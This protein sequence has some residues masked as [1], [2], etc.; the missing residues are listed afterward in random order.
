MSEI[1]ATI[2][3]TVHLNGT[4][5]DALIEQYTNAHRAVEA[6][7]MMVA[8]NGPNA[9]DYYPHG[10]LAWTSAASQHSVRLQALR[11]IANELRELAEYVYDQKEEQRRSKRVSVPAEKLPFT[12]DAID[13]ATGQSRR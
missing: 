7:I 9:R 10:D 4:S 5:A 3:P 1:N 2:K 13:E 12:M 6:A 8:E 11:R